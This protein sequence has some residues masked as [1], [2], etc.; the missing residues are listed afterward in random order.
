MS[1]YTQISQFQYY[2]HSIRLHKDIFIIDI[3]LPKEW[4]YINPMNTYSDVVGIKNNGQ[5]GKFNYLSFMSQNEM[6]DVEKSIDAI[7][8]VINF[9]KERE[10]KEEL[11]K[12]KMV[13]LQRMFENADVETLTKLEF[14]VKKDEKEPR[15]S[16]ASEGNTERQSGDTETQ[17]EDNTTDSK[18]P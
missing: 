9:N 13:E 14:N 16:M 8:A 11:M 15:V 17:E 18:D 6:D 10:L 1:L 3:K 5:K 12:K 4:E 7:H 2:F